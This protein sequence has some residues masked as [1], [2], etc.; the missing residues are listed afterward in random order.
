MTNKFN[1]FVLKNLKRFKDSK[2][3]SKIYCKLIPQKVFLTKWNGFKCYLDGRDEGVSPFIY[4]VKSFET[5]VIRVLE[6]EIKNG[7]TVVDIGANIGIMTLV[8]ARAVGE[9][10]KVYAF[11][12]EPHNFEILKKNVEI[13]NFK[14]VILINKAV[15]DT[16]GINLLKLDSKNYGAHSLHSKVIPHYNGK[17]IKIKTVTLDT[18]FKNK[19]IDLLKIDV[20]GGEGNVFKGAKN[21]LKRNIKIIMEF[22]AEGIRLT[23]NDPLKL[24]KELKRNGFFINFIKKDYYV[25]S[26]PEQVIKACKRVIIPSFLN[27]NVTGEVNLFLRKTKGNEKDILIKDP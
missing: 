9:K 23:H 8:M 6:K 12:P 18:F 17:K 11:E 2:Y 20:Q 22:W 10:G 13:N 21:I 15:S 16:N 1:V 24:L 5:S 7:M 4:F 14:N 19:N 25:H 3:G 26:Y 27:K